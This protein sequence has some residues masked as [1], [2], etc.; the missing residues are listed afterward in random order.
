MRVTRLLLVALACQACQTN[1]PDVLT[2]P[3][4]NSGEI[5]VRVGQLA[6]LGASGW[7][8]QVREVVEDSRCPLDAYCVWAGR[9]RLVV[10]LT[11][12]GGVELA[13]LL[14]SEPAGAL[15]FSGYRLDLVHVDPAP[16]SHQRIEPSQYRFR[17][18]WA[19]LPD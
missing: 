10:N 11:H 12:L 5:V 8:A 9:V 3:V 17:M 7:R 13:G 19:Y 4:I 6:S 14:S 18:R 16:Y 15:V 2:G 1:G